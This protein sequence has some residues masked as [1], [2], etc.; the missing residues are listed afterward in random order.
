M[1]EN[2]KRNSKTNAVKKEDDE[3][4]E[5]VEEKVENERIIW[6]SISIWMFSHGQAINQKNSLLRDGWHVKSRLKPTATTA[7]TATTTTT[8]KQIHSNVCVRAHRTTD[9][10]ASIFSIYIRI[11]LNVE[12]V[13]DSNI[14]RIRSH[15]RK[16]HKR[17]RAARM[18]RVRGREM[19]E[20]ENTRKMKINKVWLNNFS[21]FSQPCA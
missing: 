17:K 2:G 19:N 21:I 3:E 16:L 13:R 6:I 10:M 15:P 5:E 18:V 7:T 14:C 1:Q 8:T 11:I 9:V 4:E 12:I 20:I